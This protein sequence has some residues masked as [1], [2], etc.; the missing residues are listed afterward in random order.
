MK[1]IYIWLF[2]ALCSNLGTLFCIKTDQNPNILINKSSNFSHIDILNFSFKNNDNFPLYEKQLS[3]L[4]LYRPTFTKS[5][6]DDIGTVAMMFVRD[7]IMETLTVS[8]NDISPLCNKSITYAAQEPNHLYLMKL[9]KDSS[10]NKNDLGSYY[11]CNN[12]NYK[13]I[14]QT[15]TDSI[16]D[17]LTYIVVHVNKES[18]WY[19]ITDTRH[20]SGNFLWG[21]CVIK[22]C[23]TSEYAI[24]FKYINQV[25][26]LFPNLTSNDV[27]VIDWSEEKSYQWDIVL[28]EMIPVFLMIFFFLWSI[29]P[30]I[31]VNL[32]KCFF[33]KKD[34]LSTAIETRIE[35]NNSIQDETIEM[36]GSI[37]FS[38][39][40]YERSYNKYS[41][42]KFRSCF[43]LV[44]NAEEVLSTNVSLHSMNIN[45][46]S[47]L[48]FVKGLR[49]LNM[50]FYILGCVFK[51]LYSCP[52]KIFCN[53]AFQNL[54]TSFSF[55]FIY[56]GL[57]ISPRVFFSLSAYSLAYK[58]LC[59]FDSEIE[60]L[61]NERQTVKN[62]K[63]VEH[64][65]EDNSK[66][67]NQEVNNLENSC[68][69]EEKET[70]KKKLPN[71][72]DTENAYN[73]SNKY[74][75]S[76]YEDD[77]TYTIVNNEDRTV[78]KDKKMKSKVLPRASIFRHIINF[79]SSEIQF[80]SLLY[81]IFL[82]LHKYILYL[83]A[84]VFFRF[85]YYTLIALLYSPGPI[86]V[87]LRTQYMDNFSNYRLISMLF[88]VFNFS[89]KT[90]FIYDIYWIIINEI[91]YFITFSL[92]I[93][94][95]FR[96]NCRLDIIIIWL[97]ILAVSLKVGF[98]IFIYYFKGDP[99]YFNP[100]VVFYP[101]E[102]NAIT[103]NPFYNMPSYLI[104]L[105]F[106]LV[107]YCFQ[108][109]VYLEEGKNLLKKFLYLPCLF[110]SFFQKYQ[111]L[112]VLLTALIF[113]AFFFLINSSYVI[114]YRNFFKH[115]VYM[116]EFYRN[117]GVIIIFSVDIEFA[118]LFMWMI[119]IPLFLTGDNFIIN[120]FKHD[121]WNFI[122]R[123]YFIF[124]ILN[125]LITVYIFYQSESR[126][127]LELFN[128]IF[129]TLLVLIINMIIC[130]VF[131]IL[132][133]VPLKKLNKLIMERKNKSDVAWT[134]DG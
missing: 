56:Y 118:I 85:S 95:C 128:I 39:L 44:E 50:I 66:N 130:C 16:K 133:E 104:G 2:L 65:D 112:K 90:Y 61:E 94:Y 109:S 1:T 102:G 106:G 22:G 101:T 38:M 46:D 79:N 86:W 40:S 41:L 80:K 88:L 14:N 103:K 70:Q 36:K 28:L 18:N 49:G 60:S 57:R 3:L 127:K 45:N 83:F 111:F 98:C 55:C 59:F 29:F 64:R 7:I 63:K 10:K 124:L 121:Y 19:N 12:I 96:K 97:F 126:I 77:K 72:Y 11:D 58:L 114:I 74:S 48:S 32:F 15:W 4:N 115:D 107:N 131:Y 37:H 75:Q 116:N 43:Q 108:K 35:N 99:N 51:V 31:P 81:F 13:S 53:I 17:N 120:F 33:K 21:G 42:N 119:I 93:F 100:A 110:R 67:K 84:L 78:S 30:C 73:T 34:D 5:D 125:K 24:F 8:Q 134:N 27:N 25:T 76:L 9:L 62:T 89:K 113:T 68:L 71:S 129:F 122:S 52:I 69:D 47:G 105:F 23:N 6:S 123:P 87:Y 82:Q 132:Y 117:L 20:E 92:I 91:F 26:G 54:V